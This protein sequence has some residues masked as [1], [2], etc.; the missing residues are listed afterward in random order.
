MLQT[1]ASHLSQGTITAIM[2]YVVMWLFSAPA[3]KEDPQIFVLRTQ[4]EQQRVQL[5]GMQERIS[6]LEFT[7]ER[8]LGLLTE[9]VAQI[10]AVVKNGG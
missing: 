7:T 2:F 1:F 5:S 10:N 4:L 6:T 9:Q 3:P 8:R